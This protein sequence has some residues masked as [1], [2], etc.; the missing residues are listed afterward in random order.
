MRLAHAIKGR[1][2]YYIDALKN[3]EKLAKLITVKLN[4]LPFIKQVTANVNTGSL[5]ILYSCAENVMDDIFTQLKQ[6]VFNI[7]NKLMAM[8]GNATT[9][10]GCIL[11]NLIREINLWIK[12]K[13]G[14][15][16]DLR[17]AVAG[18]FIIRGLRKVMTM[19]QRPNGPQMLWWAFSIL[20]G[21]G[22]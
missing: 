15:L 11:L 4:E 1:R 7:G 22:K 17:V 18:F 8:G 5:L 13:T 21:L 2:R 3:N 20:R 9:Q 10:I 12:T 16:M 19:G 6:R 14:N